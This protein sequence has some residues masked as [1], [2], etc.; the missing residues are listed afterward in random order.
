MKK[1]AFMLAMSALLLASCQ[2]ND[3]L[4]L[5]SENEVF[6][7]S[8]ESFDAQTKTSMTQNRQ[9]VWS[10]NDRLAI[11]QGSTIADE[12]KATDASAG[13]SNAIFDIVS[14]NS[15]V[16][17]SFSAGV[18]VSRNIALYPYADNLSLEA[19][20]LDDEGSAYE[21]AGFVLP[22]TQNYAADSFGNGSFPM[23]AV[24]S[25]MTDHTLKFRNL[26]GAMKLQFKGT[27]NVKSIKVEG[28]NNE[29]LSGAAVITAYATNLTPAI[30]MA[31][32]AGTSV[33]LDCGDGVQLNESTATDFFIALPPVLFSQGFTVTVTDD[34][35]RT[36]TFGA[37]VA[38]TVLRSSI[39]TMPAVVLDDEVAEDEEEDTDSSIKVLDIAFDK[40]TLTLAPSTSY[41]LITIVVP[42]TAEDKTLTWSS[43]DPAIATVDQSG[44]V[45]AVSDGTT[46]ITAV[47]AGGASKSCTVKVISV[48]TSV[49]TK[50]YVDEYGINHGKGV[51]IGGT[52]WAPVNCGYKAP[53]Y[54]DGGNVTDKGYPYGKL[55]QWG[56]R[57]GQGYSDYYDSEPLTYPGPVSAV[58]G[59][60]RSMSDYYFIGSNNWVETRDNSMWNSG[61]EVSPVK[62]SNDPC[63]EGWRVPTYVE[64]DIVSE[65]YSWGTND[66][67]Q[68][69]HYF[70]GVTRTN[71]DTAP[72]IESESRVFFPAAG[73]RFNSS[74]SSSSSRDRERGYYWS[75]RPWSHDSAYYLEFE[76][77]F[78]GI[79]DMQRTS[80][81]SGY[82]VRCVQVID[83]VAEF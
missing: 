23:V 39:L 29:K 7:A 10:S 51:A 59:Q 47:A 40:S 52:V 62:T 9:V 3:E 43:S 82:S 6:T 46:T 37:D 77:W 33:T 19:S 24:T 60:D 74:S 55:Y 56:R 68:K 45:T 79:S 49:A 31:E 53:T 35:S 27:Q 71:Y 67:G 73:Y 17:G 58:F 5:V 41:S 34:A 21:I 57:Y 72:L 1:I 78:A 8:V 20:T 80:C 14:D 30:T 76:S 42:E 2:K 70:S 63:P 54:D 16:N 69:G 32:T 61:T 81:A 48:P 28:K 50:D 26:L 65:V 64:L 11:F 44:V 66:N 36:Y 75:S 15:E 13:K 4:S 18:E 83:D 12:Y 25:S 22:S 38:N